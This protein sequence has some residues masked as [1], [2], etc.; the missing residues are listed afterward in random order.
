MSKR[1]IDKIPKLNGDCKFIRMPDEFDYEK[2]RE[3]SYETDLDKWAYEFQCRQ[4]N[5]A[6]KSDVSQFISVKD[7]HVHLRFSETKI[8]NTYSGKSHWVNGVYT[9]NDFSMN[10]PNSYLI[11]KTLRSIEDSGAISTNDENYENN[12]EKYPITTTRIHPVDG[13]KLH[14]ISEK[15]F[16]KFVELQSK[17]KFNRAFMVNLEMPTE[18]LV[19]QI[20]EF[21]NSEKT[22]IKADETVI[23]D[24]IKKL[25]IK[26]KNN[27]ITTQETRQLNNLTSKRYKAV[28]GRKFR[29]LDVPRMRNTDDKTPYLY[30][31]IGLACYDLINDFQFTQAD[32][33]RKYLCYLQFGEQD[34]YATPDHNILNTTLYT[35]Q[36]MINNGWKK[37]TGKP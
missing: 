16:C 6:D 37:L 3:L 14:F 7:F 17:Y 15:D 22:K 31:A 18:I 2:Y 20:R 9:H 8:D 27:T 35:V 33:Y 32:V 5:G 34:F 26:N 13:G 4:K 21:I 36:K 11:G 10:A 12:K 25:K 29:E 28:N 1:A 30:W 23:A 19:N 24:K